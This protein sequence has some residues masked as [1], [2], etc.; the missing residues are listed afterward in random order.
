MHL[1]KSFCGIVL[2]TP[3]HPVSFLSYTQCKYTP[4][5][6]SLRGRSPWAPPLQL[7]SRSQPVTRLKRWTHRERSRAL[8]PWPWHSRLMPEEPH[9]G[10]GTGLQ[11]GG[12]RWQKVA[13]WNIFKNHPHNRVHQLLYTCPTLLSTDWNQ[14]QPPQLRTT[15]QTWSWIIGRSSTLTIWFIYRAQTSKCSSVWAQCFPEKN[16][17]FSFCQSQQWIFFTFYSQCISC[18]L[19]SLREVKLQYQ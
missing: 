13:M 15:R 17:Y 16:I 11:N 5:P 10:S 14:F 6:P 7:V 2:F 4:P 3:N 9:S 8:S 18:I 19:S 12:G 1:C